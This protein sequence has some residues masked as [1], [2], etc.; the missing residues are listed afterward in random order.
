MDKEIFKHYW[1]SSYPKSGNTWL[2]MFIQNY[3]EG[4][5]QAVDTLQKVGPISSSM[6]FFIKSSKDYNIQEIRNT[7]KHTDYANELPELYREFYNNL[8]RDVYCKS[9]Q[10]FL[11]NE[12]GEKLFQSN[13]TDGV[14]YLVRN[15]IDIVPSLANHLQL[16]FDDAI[17]LLNYENALFGKLNKKVI[18]EDIVVRLNKKA[19]QFPNKVSSWSKNVKHWTE[20]T[21]IP[22]LI[23]RYEDMVDAPEIEFKKIIKF[24]N[25]TFD[26][27]RFN[28]A[29]KNTQFDS[30]QKQE[31]IGL[32]KEINTNAKFFKY[33][34]YGKGRE[35][36]NE[37]QIKKILDNNV[38]MMLKFKYI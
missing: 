17:R 26:K 25:F 31:S 21:D 2:R 34:T 9:H 29:L 37:A 5:L 16:S 30:F 18:D 15:P 24:L 19:G 12:N 27:N 35:L 1:L 14:V 36:L 38:E 4:E 13:A 3:K 10:D 20:Q 7:F 8:D 6:L 33:G 32:F 11:T 28:N 23:V 22:I